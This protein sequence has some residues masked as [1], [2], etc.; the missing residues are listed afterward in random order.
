MTGK[1]ISKANPRDAELLESAQNL[2][3]AAYAYWKA[4]QKKLGA[5]AVI[6]LEDNDGHLVVFTRG[7]YKDWIM[8]AVSEIHR[9]P[10]A[11]FIE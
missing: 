8:D 10:E 4:Y 6:Y 2:L 5:S 9:D 7:E 11:R 3:N 1:T